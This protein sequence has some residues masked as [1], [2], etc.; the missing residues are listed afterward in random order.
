MITL[1]KELEDMATKAMQEMSEKGLKYKYLT[2]DQSFF[3]TVDEQR[4][5]KGLL[6][7]EKKTTKHAVFYLYHRLF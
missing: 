7:L 5:Q 1:S 6:L 3:I 4:N 2:E